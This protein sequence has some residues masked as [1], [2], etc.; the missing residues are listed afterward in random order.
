MPQFY[1]AAEVLWWDLPPWRWV[2]HAN[3]TATLQTL[4]TSTYPVWPRPDHSGGCWH[5]ARKKKR[6]MRAAAPQKPFYS[7]QL[8]P[9]SARRSVSKAA[10]DGER[11]YTTD[12][13]KLMSWSSDTWWFTRNVISGHQNRNCHQSSFAKAEKVFSWKMWRMIIQ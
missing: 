13:W 9:L 10:Q 12:S 8:L 1:E 5:P 2:T 11:K 4:Q 3:H 6:N 7:S